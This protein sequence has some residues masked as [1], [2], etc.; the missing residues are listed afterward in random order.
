MKKKIL[1][2]A[3]ALSVLLSYAQESWDA[4][5]MFQLDI[6]DNAVMY[7]DSVG[8]PDGKIDFCFSTSVDLIKTDSAGNVKGTFDAYSHYSTFTVY[9]GDTLFV[10]DG[11]IVN[12]SN[13]DTVYSQ[14]G[15]YVHKIA[16]SSSELYAYMIFLGIRGGWHI[17]RI[18]DR[19]ALYVTYSVVDLYCSGG[20]I[21]ALYSSEGGSTSRLTLIDEVSNSIE[22]VTVPVGSLTDIAVYRGSVYAYSASNKTLYL[23]KES[24][25]TIVNAIM[26]SRIGTEPVHYGLDGKVISPSV[27]GIHIIRY[28]DNSV[29][30]SIVS[31]Q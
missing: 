15:T 4:V 2:F 8:T 26:K 3:S 31:F 18:F 13:G 7:I 20:I 23:L 1:L 11:K 24:D 16:A 12:A 14:P 9:K 10:E 21:Y 30:K 19:K 22:K 25:Q 29:K 5:K 28:P 27:P 17:G 6:D